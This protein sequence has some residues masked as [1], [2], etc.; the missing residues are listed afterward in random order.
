MSK[1]LHS[2]K[3]LIEGEMVHENDTWTTIKVSGDHE[4]R[5]ARPGATMPF[6]DGETITVRSSFLKAIP[7]DVSP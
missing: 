1:W 7:T 6:A 5:S 2:R 3:G 4:L